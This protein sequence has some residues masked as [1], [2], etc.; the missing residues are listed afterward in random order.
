[1]ASTQSFLEICAEHHRRSRWDQETATYCCA[2]CYRHSG[3]TSSSNSFLPAQARPFMRAC[4]GC[5]AKCCGRCTSVVEIGKTIKA[6]FAAFDTDQVLCTACLEYGKLECFS[7]ST[8]TAFEF[9]TMCQICDELVCNSCVW[10]YQF[11]TDP[12]LGLCAG[13]YRSAEEDDAEEIVW[14]GR[15]AQPRS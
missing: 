9:I 12:V 10:A 15:N 11:E 6:A 1:M 2:L 5:R 7:C 4:F 14:L 13:C 8:W 3:A